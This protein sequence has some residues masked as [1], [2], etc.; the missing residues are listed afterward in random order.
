LSR[1]VALGQLIELEMTQ[2][3]VTEEVGVDLL[4]V[5]TRPRQPE[6]NRHFGM[7]EE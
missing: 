4:G 1:K 7:A 5:L 2:V 6:T 3:Q